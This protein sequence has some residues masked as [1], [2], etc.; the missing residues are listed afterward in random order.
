M[1][2][3]SL[4]TLILFLWRSFVERNNLEEQAYI[5]VTALTARGRSRVDEKYLDILASS[6]IVITC[7]PNE[8]EG[9]YRL[10]EALLS[11]ALVFVDKMVVLEMLP[12][13]YEHKKHL[14]FYDST[15]Q[16]EFDE[17]LTYY[18]DNEEEARQIAMAG[19]THTLKR[20]MPKDRVEYVLSKIENKL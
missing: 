1:F 5:G 15:N 4:L 13:P 7:N 3:F 17:L 12:H 16:D 11:G 14:I 19:Y 10:W 20:H 6:K 8:W 2:W 18:I 9:D